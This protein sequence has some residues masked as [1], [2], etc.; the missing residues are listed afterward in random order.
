MD[1]F[2]RASAQEAKFLRQAL[3]IQKEKSRDKGESMTEC[4]DCGDPIP[5][6]RRKAAPGCV[7][8]IECQQEHEGS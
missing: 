5:E 6:A 8:C 1:F 3:E 4:I 7:R 2:D